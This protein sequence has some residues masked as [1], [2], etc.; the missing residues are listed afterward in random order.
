MTIEITLSDADKQYIS[1]RTAEI[2]IE[3]L[4]TI[5]L[6]TLFVRAHTVAEVSQLISYSPSTIRDFIRNGRKTKKGKMVA[7]PAIEITK[8]DYRIR[9]SHLERWLDLF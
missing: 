4:L 7:L 9:P 3:E 2:M 5:H 6:S 8:G 1:Q